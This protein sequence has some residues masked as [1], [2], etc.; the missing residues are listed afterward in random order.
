MKKIISILITLCLVTAALPSQA[1]TFSDVENSVAIDVVTGLGIMS[2][3]T[4]GTFLPDDNMTRA[5]FAQ[6]AAQ[7]YNYGQDEN[8]VAEWKREFFEG[9]FE[10]T[11]LI[12]PEVMN[13]DSSEL[14]SDVSAEMDAYNAI[15][16]VSQKN[17]MVGNGNGEF[18]PDGNITV[19]QAIKVMVSML[20]YATQAG[21]KGGYPNGY[22]SVATELGLIKGLKNFSEYATREDIA[23]LIYNALDV[24]LMQ[25]SLVSDGYVE[26]GT[27]EDETFLT[28]LLNLT[29]EEG[30][31]TDNGYTALSEKSAYGSGFVVVNDKKFRVTDENEYIRDF[32]GR[33]IE[34]YYSLDEDRDDIIYARLTNKDEAVTF[35]GSEFEDYTNSQVIYSP[36]N[37]GSKTVNTIAAPFMVKNNTAHSSFDNSIFD[38]NYGTVT[39]ITPEG[40]GKADLIILKSYTNFNISFVDLINNNIHSAT[41]LLGNTVSIDEDEKDVK[42]Y[43]AL[44]QESS[45][46]ILSSGVVT[47]ICMGDSVVEIYVSDIIESDFYITGMRTNDNGEHIISGNDKSYAISSDYLKSNGGVLPLAG[48]SYKLYI[49]MFGKVVDIKATAGEY[50]VGFLNNVKRL[51]PEDSGE[52]TVRIT[53]YDL[54]SARI[55]YVFTADK[56]SL[57][58]TNGD[59]RT[60]NMEKDSEKLY[61]ILYSYIMS[62]D[63]TVRMGGMFRYKLNEEGQFSE[64]EIA[65]ELENSTDDSSRLVMIAHHPNGGVSGGNGMLCGDIIYGSGTTIIKCNYNSE[66]FDTSDGYTIEKGGSIS[67]GTKKTEIRAYAT[68]NNSSFADYIIMTEEVDSFISSESHRVGIVT[69]LYKGI[70]ADDEAVDYITLGSNQY[71]LAEG[72]LTAGKVKNMQGKAS[73]TDGNGTE[74]FFEIEKGD[75]VRYAF[76]GENKINQIVLVYDADADYSSGVKVGETVYNGWSKRGNLAGCFDGVHTTGGVQMFSNPFIIKHESSS[77][78][79]DFPN[80]YNWVSG[81]NGNMRVIMA[82]VVRKG[83][84]YIVVTSR[85]LQENPADIEFGGDGVYPTDLYKVTNCTVVTIDNNRVTVETQG[86]SDLRDYASMGTSCDRIFITSRLGGT[87]NAIVYR[88]ID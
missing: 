6:V 12:P 36:D 15:T 19:E 46:A 27:I 48:N 43:D 51:D 21:R 49:D 17:I 67:E 23:V 1:M 83:D 18:E 61:N 28:K 60:Y 69:N 74:H 10:E 47:S 50:K 71:E 33:D 85:N 86:V 11:Q 82:S 30:R 81:Y 22:I 37:G 41:S 20:G 34:I 65:G 13:Q 4:D 62:T 29:H 25:M 72:I 9:A 70:N 16:L 76:N 58:D 52:Y 77:D 56:V 26:Y 38:F 66:R 7:I 32:L 84:G 8:A 35:T 40:S 31:M 64:L 42:I 2:G 78:T 75:L 63:G 3:N 55:E 14:F 88:Y 39:V 59:K 80:P 54:T 24:E 53:Y 44:G 45:V 5:D 57:I 73:Y 68:K 79:P 87:R